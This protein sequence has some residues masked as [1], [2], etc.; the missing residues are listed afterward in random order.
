MWATL[1][2]QTRIG[3]PQP[4][5]GPAMRQM[6]R[7]DLLHVPHINKPIPDRIRIDH[8]HRPMLA[9]IQATQLIGPDLPLQPGLLD[10][11]FEGRLQL[12]AVLSGAAWTRSARVTLI[13]ADKN[14]ML[15][16]SHFPVLLT[17]DVS[18]IP[19]AAHTGF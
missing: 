11:V 17:L 14:M 9:L 3:Q 6:L 2:I 12:L 5:H 8:H 18:L 4:L 13:R 19:C 16:L 1:C 10:R 15:E 7:D